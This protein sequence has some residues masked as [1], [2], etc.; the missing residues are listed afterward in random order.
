LKHI[1]I[2]VLNSVIGTADL[3]TLGKD[4]FFT[5][6]LE[7]FLPH[8][9]KPPV[10]EHS[11]ARL[12]FPKSASLKRIW[13][14]SGDLGIGFLGKQETSSSTFYLVYR[15]Y[16]ADIARNHNFNDEVRFP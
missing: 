12:H 4:T 7:V 5:A 13:G 16:R 1:R 3:G 6:A 10:V 15:G 9:A 2:G 14:I 8:P 11:A